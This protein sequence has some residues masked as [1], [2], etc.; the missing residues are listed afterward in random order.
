MK[1]VIR[2]LLVATV[3]AAAAAVTSPSLRPSSFSGWV[4]VAAILFVLS[5]LG[6][7]AW[8]GVFTEGLGQ[9]IS[10]SRFSAARIAIALAL[11]LPLFAVGC[12]VNWLLGG[13]S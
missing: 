11:I 5:L 4:G 1:T 7:W 2:Y 12:G 3:V 9:A 13:Q 10:K 8:E 6:E